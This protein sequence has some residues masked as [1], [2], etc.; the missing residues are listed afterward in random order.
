MAKPNVYQIAARIQQ[1]KNELKIA[2]D[3][4]DF[5]RNPVR[6]LQATR[7]QYEVNFTKLL[8][9]HWLGLRRHSRISPLVKSTDH[10]IDGNAFDWDEIQSTYPILVEIIDANQGHVMP[11]E[12]IGNFIEFADSQK[13]FLTYPWTKLYRFMLMQNASMIQAGIIQVYWKK[14]VFEHQQQIANLKREEA[15]IFKSHSLDRDSLT[16]LMRSVVKDMNRLDREIEPVQNQL[17]KYQMKLSI[18][19]ERKLQLESQIESIK[20]QLSNLPDT[21]KE[22]LIQQATR[23]R[24]T[25]MDLSQFE[26]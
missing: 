26:L 18:L 24:G 8:D 12:F 15:E 17:H 5:F 23:K 22:S 21:A 20:N 6:A 13:A 16:N 4:L 10:N 2:R 14:R 19:N 3:A 1:E 11:M 9:A 25:K 7:H